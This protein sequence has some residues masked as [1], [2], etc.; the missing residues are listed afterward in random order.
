MA[1]EQ[2][3]SYTYNVPNEGTKSNF[4]FTYPKQYKTT[5]QTDDCTYHALD[6]A[7]AF[8]R[9]AKEETDSDPS[10]Q[11]HLTNMKLQK[12]V[13]YAQLIMLRYRER[14]IHC[15]NTHA[16][17][18]GP[19]C[20]KFYRKIKAFGPREFSLDDTQMAEVFRDAKPLDEESMEVVRLVWTKL[21][22]A[23][24]YQ[25]SELTH[26]PYSAWAITYE[27]NRYGIIPIERMIA[28]GY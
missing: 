7:N 26:R 14:P 24:A 16:W 18:Y 20:P 11:F 6:I 3:G 2:Q 19:V 4:S 25:L 21:K 27:T 12:L 5:E 28:Q 9:L 1:E 8:L 15:D 22:E 13:Y 10:L 23:S 17:Q